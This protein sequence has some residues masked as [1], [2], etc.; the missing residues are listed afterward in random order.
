MSNTKDSLDDFTKRRKIFDEYLKVQG[1]NKTTCPSCAFPTLSERGAYDICIICGW[2][3]D[4]QD[5][6]NADKMTGG[7]N[8]NMSLL[9]SRIQIGKELKELANN[10]N[11]TVNVE[12][13]EVLNILHQRD[14]FL[15]DYVSKNIEG[16]TT[17]G[18]PAFFEYNNLILKSKNLLIKK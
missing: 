15:K 13:S 16:L 17:T 6:W 5:D 3:D 12:P 1:I 8:G 14:T 9:E 18:D 10:Q 2:E 11:G 4:G 7:P